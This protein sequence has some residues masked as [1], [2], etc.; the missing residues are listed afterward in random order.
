MVWRI[1]FLGLLALSLGACSGS[2]PDTEAA[3]S[4]SEGSALQAPEAG[5]G[6]PARPISRLPRAAGF[7]GMA[8]GQGLVSYA[9]GASAGRRDGA[10]H[11][12][13]VELS[14]AHA[15]ASIV[16]GELEVGAPS[17]GTLRYRYQRHVEHESGDWTWVGTLQGPTGAGEAVITF[18]SDAAFGSLGQ[19]QGE[20]LRLMTRAGRAWLVETDADLVANIRNRATRPAGP[21]YLVP[22]VLTDRAADVPQAAGTLPAVVGATA[23]GGVVVDAVL[24]YTTGFAAGLGGVSQA[25]TRLN[26]LVEVVNQA[27]VNS[28]VDARIRLV[29]ALQVD[30]PDA[31][32]N[33]NALE[34]LT[35]Y[36]SGSGFVSPAA[37]FA[38]LRAAR[39]EYGA[40]LVSLVRKFNDP[41]NDGCGVAWLI[42]SS[43][44][45]VRARDEPF[46]Y[47]VVSDGTDVGSDGKTYFCRDETL[48]HEFGHNMGSQHDLDNAKR[49][50][51]TLR[52]GAFDYS[53]GYST[54]LDNGNFHT[55]MAY[56]AK[57]RTPRQT[58]YRVF[59]NPRITY[60]GGFPCGTAEQ[61]DNA[62]SLGQT[63]PVIAGF[64]A[65]V[66]GDTPPPQQGARARDDVDGDG[67][68]DLLLRSGDA[69]FAYWIMSGATPT[70]YSPAFAQPG[71]YELAARGDFNGNG[72]LD[73][74]WSRAADRQLLMWQGDGTGFT[75]LP[76]RTVSAGWKVTGAADI[77]GDGKTDLLLE[78]AAAGQFAYWIMDGASPIRF[79]PAFAQP[80]GS[81]R[82]GAGD[83]NGDGKLDIAYVLADRRLQVW[84]GDGNGFVASVVGD[85]PAG[86]EVSGTGDRNGD[87]RDDL[88][89]FNAQRHWITFWLLDGTSPAPFNSVFVAPAGYEL[90][91]YGDYN[92]DKRVDLTWARRSDRML[93]QWQS[94][95]SS[96][97][98]IQV[99][100]YA[101]GWRPLD[102]PATATSP[103]SGILRG[104]VDG[105]RRSDL[106]L[107]NGVLQA[108][109]Y[110]LMNGSVVSR[111]SAVFLR[112]PGYTRVATGD[113]NGDTRL[114]MVWMR[115]SDRHLLLWRG[116]GTGFT[117]L[118]IRE[119]SSGWT[120]TGA[121]DVDGDGRSDLLL[122]NAASGG[123]A[124]WIMNG[125]E[126]VRYSPVL[127][128]PAGYSQAAVGDF[129][130]D[131]K[132][133]IVWARASDRSL[134]LWAGDGVGFAA[135]PIGVYSAGWTV[136]GAGDIDGDGKS[137]LLLTH[138][139]GAFA[140]WIMNGAVPV[141]YSQVF[142]PPAG[143][144]LTATGDY[145]G[146]RRHDLVWTNATDRSV[147]MWLGDGTG[148]AQALVGASS[149]D[150]QVIDP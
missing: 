66:V 29:H 89:F 63:I 108:T 93:L 118:G 135:Q 136:A 96:F 46:G 125:H 116:D 61:A 112:P 131:G 44:V 128:Q 59:S 42:G 34:E 65:R 144:V 84:H 25:I 142:A 138:A 24:G 130:G 28:Q 122:A 149:P 40:D 109:A 7:A 12:H 114:D 53:F 58:R 32:A 92:G 13:P 54:A 141:R 70:R 41:E 106:I 146:D 107:D 60:C 27:Y 50:D 143:H 127:A 35:G 97:V 10:Y 45:G 1:F 47:S 133:D 49:D 83:F 81:L 30:Y 18:G 110:W 11:W 101:I 91:A 36:K 119:M 77:N 75:E 52:Y 123:M 129:N 95:S 139:T 26:F 99:R 68:S 105:S 56:A 8:D 90:A 43:R 113:F 31:T 137:D 140:Y 87:G 2:H 22:P 76:I 111:Y 23:S 19:P 48:A 104:D 74:V 124:Y 72:R 88:I 4:V 132:A 147:L 20:P 69:S 14:E 117:P 103:L 64:R 94:S 100:D 3:G 115:G 71:G 62:R 150:W 85:V 67:R 39:E 57:D 6:A 102:L 5:P 37:A 86:W 33:A 120:V 126:P 73:L 98:E 17:G 9:A 15:L 121:A 16:G 82:A 134:L 21:D 148:F 78:N 38:P 80:A 79:S 55:I 145:N 51:G